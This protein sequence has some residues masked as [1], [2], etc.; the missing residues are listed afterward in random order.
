MLAD[1]AAAAGGANAFV[2]SAQ[3][4]GAGD[5]RNLVDNF[6]VNEMKAGSIPDT[7]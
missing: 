3:S 4:D 6:D 2:S 1:A 5:F 7:G